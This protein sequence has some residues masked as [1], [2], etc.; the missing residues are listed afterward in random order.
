MQKQIGNLIFTFALIVILA[1]ATY[2]SLFWPRETKLFPTTMGVVALILSLI[3]FAR[4][5]FRLYA[6]GAAIAGSE[7][8]KEPV[9]LIGGLRVLAWLFGFG[10]AIWI[11]G[12][13]I[14]AFLFVFLFVKFRA[15]RSTLESL[16]FGVAAA[17]A[18]Y[19]IFVLV[20]N[21]QVYLG[22]ILDYINNL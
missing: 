16:G 18:I 22:L 9:E 2:E 12:F 1:A 6:S 3:I 20:F 13:H 17:A 21:Q 11:F 4:D 7:G 19:V 15:N 8:G 14:A 10:L 5:S